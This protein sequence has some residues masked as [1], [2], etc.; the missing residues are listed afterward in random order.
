MVGADLYLVVNFGTEGSDKVWGAVVE[1]RGMGNISKEVLGYKFFLGA[2]DFPAFFVEDGVLVRVNPSLVSTR[3]RSEEMREGGKID[4]VDVVEGG[5]RLYGGG[6]D[7]RRV[8]KRW[9]GA[10]DDVL[11]GWRA[12]WEDGRDWQWDVFDFFDE[13]EVGNDRVEIGSV[14]GDVGEEVQRLVLN[15]VE[16]ATSDGEEGFEEEA[17]RWS[18]DVVVEEWRC[19]GENILT[20]EERVLDGGSGGIDVG[21]VG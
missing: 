2:P 1:G 21:L 18:G 7:G 16:L 4:V 19:R 17:G 5:K 11:R 9:G 6:G 12:S 20:R 15:F 3:W 14:G 10:S 8:T 13:W